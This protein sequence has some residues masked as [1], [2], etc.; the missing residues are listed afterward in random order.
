MSSE[1]WGDPRIRFPLVSASLSL[2]WHRSWVPGR[3]FSDQRS[4]PSPFN[5]GWLATASKQAKQF[6]D[7][8]FTPAAKALLEAAWREQKRL[9]E[10]K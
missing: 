8:L 2:S 3:Y 6:I 5:S 7:A 10:K 1:R 9:G 4:G